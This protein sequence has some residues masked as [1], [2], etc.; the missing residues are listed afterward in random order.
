MAWQ[1]EPDRKGPGDFFWFALELLPDE[2][3][4]ISIAVGAVFTLVWLLG[5]LFRSF[6]SGE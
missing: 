6:F 4:P 5:M 3:W 1:R 2:F